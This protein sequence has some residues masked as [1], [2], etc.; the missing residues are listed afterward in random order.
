MGQELLMAS[1]AA[2]A[3]DAA[4]ASA[5][6]ADHFDDGEDCFWGLHMWPQSALTMHNL[7]GCRLQLQ[8]HMLLQDRQACTQLQ[9]LEKGLEQRAVEEEEDDSDDDDED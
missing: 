3:A 2:T 7:L 4:S 6:V 5:A 1:P 8:K 9:L